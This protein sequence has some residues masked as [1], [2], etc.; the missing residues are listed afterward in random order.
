MPGPFSEARQG[1][2]YLF[3]LPAELR[4]YI[5]EYALTENASLMCNVGE[6]ATA[7]PRLCTTYCMDG[8]M[9]ECT[10]N[11]LRLVCRSFH[12]ETKGLSLRYNDITFLCIEEFEHFLQLCS[13]RWQNQLRKVTIVFC[14]A[15]DAEYP[16]EILRPAV[17]L[18]TR[19]TSQPLYD[20]CSQH[21]EARV[22]RGDLGRLWDQTIA[23][24]PPENALD[25]PRKKLAYGVNTLRDWY[26]VPRNER[27]LDNLRF[28]GEF[29]EP[30][31][32]HTAPPII[33]ARAPA[34]QEAERRILEEG[35]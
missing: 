15:E 13:P 26:S 9:K 16:H 32:E 21:H 4:D 27:L 35:C 34:F 28:V 22:L 10:A 12:D 23:P 33:E 11:P 20:F 6:D 1:R 14:H 18:L 19:R 5:Y 17:H 30:L 29:R 8:Q 3:D 2:S 7:V 31:S 25:N 24:A